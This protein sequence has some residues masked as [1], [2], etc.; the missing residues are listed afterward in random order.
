MS[1]E[2]KPSDFVCTKEQS[3]RLKEL[4]ITQ[5]SLFWHTQDKVPTNPN[6]HYFDWPQQSMSWE[7]YLGRRSEISTSRVFEEYPAYT[8]EELGNLLP[9]TVRI[10]YES[11]RLTCKKYNGWWCVDYVTKRNESL[12][13]PFVFNY[14]NEAQERAS[15]LIYLLENKLYE[16]R[17]D[18]G[19]SEKRSGKQPRTY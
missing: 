11:Y 6:L 4:G 15:M 3:K 14:K 9:R 16:L 18:T 17:A 12:P 8:S 10:N 5:P 1:S 19:N 2:L 13:T 7:I